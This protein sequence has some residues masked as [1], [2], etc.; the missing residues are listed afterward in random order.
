MK[1]IVLMLLACASLAVSARA[2]DPLVVQALGRIEKYEALEPDLAEGDVDTANY[3]LNQLG[4]A[5]KRLGAVSKQDDA[6][7]IAAKQRYD[8]LWAKIEAKANAAG[9]APEVSYDYAALVSLNNAINAAYE[10]LK[11]LS[12]GHLADDFRQKSI[13]KEL[14]DFGVRLAAFPAGDE[15]VEIVRG[16]LA[17]FQKLFDIGMA[18]LQA[19]RE[20]APAIS[21]RLDELSA[22]YAS[23]NRPGDLEHPFSEAQIRSWAADMRRWREQEIP[24]DLAFLADA[25]TNSVVNQQK[26]SGLRN[27]VG[28]SWTRQ[29]DEL[30]KLVRERIASDVIEG[31]N[32]SAFILETDPADENQILN[33]ILGKGAFD[34]N[35]QWLRAGEHAVAM[36]RVY[37]ATMQAPAVLGPT[38]TDP[39]AP[40][41][42][43]PDRDAQAALVDRAIAHLKQLAVQALDAVR[44]PEPASTDPELIAIAE[45]TLKNPDY[46]VGAWKALVI[47]LDRSHKVR[48]EA[49]L[50][51]G[52]V[53]TTISF[54]EYAWD[55][56]QVT[57][58]EEHE[59][60]LWL[61]ANRL[62]RYESGDPTT[63]VGRWILSNR[64]E[65]TPIL[66]EHV[67]A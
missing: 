29:L 7:W 54:Y 56:F 63:P 22:K 42:E 30:E 5:G 12:V 10:N 36:A 8:A 43:F 14:A 1:S 11:L 65:L 45:E 38:I 25:A 47:N 58:V 61:F 34:E 13:R 15:N 33:R 23:Q 60:Q 62:K 35:M 40:R 19:D 64:F 51:P 44:L 4:W 52:A 24:T 28:D 41:P 59:G 46:D 18:Q 6:H 16:N 37:D 21:A 55:E 53:Y 27:H 57:T 32:V 2:Q 66:P 9:A 20:R 50:A 39:A 49:W 3:Y 48:R 31:Q 26:V 67:D 17:N